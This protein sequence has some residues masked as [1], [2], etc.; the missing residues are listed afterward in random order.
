MVSAK[1]TSNAW[2]SPASK[3]WWECELPLR[4]NSMAFIHTSSGVDN[5]ANYAHSPPKGCCTATAKLVWV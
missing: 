5:Q 1:Q 3:A 4:A 2:C